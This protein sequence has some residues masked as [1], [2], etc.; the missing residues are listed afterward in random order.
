MEEILMRPV[1]AH[2]RPLIVDRQI[3]EAMADGC[4]D[5]LFLFDC[6]LRLV[7]RLLWRRDTT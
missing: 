2:H 4:T 3:A 6:V 7:R 1:D 5:L